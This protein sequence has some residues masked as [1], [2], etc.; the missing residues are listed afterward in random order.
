MIAYWNGRYLPKDEIAVSPD[1]RGFLFA[2]GIYDVVRAYEGRLFETRAHLDRLGRGA[3]ALRFKETDFLYLAD[4]AGRLIEENK[5]AAGEATVYFQVT[6]GAAPRTHCFPP[7]ETGLTVY[8][9]ARPFAPHREDIE[10]GINILL[11]SDP[12]WARCDIKTVGLTANVLANQTARESQARESVFVR[13]GAVL[14]GTH[15]NFFAVFAGRVVTPPLTN[16]I[17]GGITRRVV[18]GICREHGIPFGEE[19]IFEADLER[20]DEL[21]IVGTT[22]EVTPVVR[23]HGRPF[24]S[25]A[26]GPVAVRLQK[27]LRE[28]TR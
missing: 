17:L 2:D 15:T 23:I 22:T 21:M 26:P 20:A 12:R 19:P 5:L 14:E 3:R 6:R 8:A 25:G 7:P 28:M 1:D 11:L 24:R 9:A 16:Y 13:D 4:V 27:A 10:N 18:L